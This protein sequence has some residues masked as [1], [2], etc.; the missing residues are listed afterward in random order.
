MLLCREQ[1]YLAPKRTIARPSKTQGRATQ[2]IQS[3]IYPGRANPTV[4]GHEF[5]RSFR[6]RENEQHRERE[7]RRLD[8]QLPVVREHESLVGPVVEVREEVVIAVAAAEMFDVAMVA[9]HLRRP[10][11]LAQGFSQLRRDRRRDI[12]LRLREVVPANRETPGRERIGPREQ[13]RPVEQLVEAQVEP[14]RL[15]QAAA[16]GRELSRFA[17]GVALQLFGQ[18]GDTDLGRRLGDFVKHNLHLAPALLGQVLP[19][20]VDRRGLFL[21]MQ[22]NRAARVAARRTAA[23]KEWR[24]ASTKCVGHSGSSW[25]SWSL[26]ISRNAISSLTFL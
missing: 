14:H 12:D 6:R 5:E 1:L 2:D 3:S 10:V 26:L 23:T 7:P 11:E 25:P 24:S 19:R 15:V 4:V 21:G 20:G 9:A 8:S 13:R 22:V 18:R 16:A 17:R